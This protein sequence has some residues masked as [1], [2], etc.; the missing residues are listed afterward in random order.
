[1]VTDWQVFVVWL[2]SVIRAPEYDTTVVRVVQTGKEV[3]VVTNLKRDMRADLV[4]RE[5]SL[6]LEGTVV[7]EDI[8]VGRV[9]GKHTLD[10]LA[11]DRVDGTAEGSE[12][13]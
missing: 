10:V 5:Q 7:L 9:L 1:M 4:E 2:Q 11:N 6:F 3:G 13:I 12:C 8:G